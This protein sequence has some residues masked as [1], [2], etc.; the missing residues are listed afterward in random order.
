MFSKLHCTQCQS[1]E[2]FYKKEGHHQIDLSIT[3]QDSSLDDSQCILYFKFSEKSC[4][5][6]T[7]AQLGGPCLQAQLFE[8][9]NWELWQPGQDPI[10]KKGKETYLT[11]DNF[12]F[13]F[14]HLTLVNIPQNYCSQAY[15]GR[16]SIIKRRRSE[17]S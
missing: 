17:A 7:R 4:S 2:M 12:I 5:K 13:S 10:L 9:L 6:E 11:T 14:F 8:R 15:F 16:P 1:Q 3:A